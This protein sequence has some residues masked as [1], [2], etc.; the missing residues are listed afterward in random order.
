MSIEESQPSELAAREE[1]LASLQGDIDDFIS[2][3]DTECQTGHGSKTDYFLHL[4]RPSPSSSELTV[5]NIQFRGDLREKGVFRDFLKYVE[6]RTALS[7]IN[8][9]TIQSDWLPEKLAAYG[10]TVE[11]QHAVK[12]LG[13]PERKEFFFRSH[14]LDYEVLRPLSHIWGN[15][16]LSWD[17]KNQAYL[18]EKDSFASVLNQLIREISLTVVP[19]RYHDNEDVLVQYVRTHLNWPLIKKGRVWTGEDYDV[20]LQQGGFH[21]IDEKDFVAAAT[22]RVQAAL[23]RNQHHYDQMEEGHRRMLASVLTSILY[24]RE[25]LVPKT[26]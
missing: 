26:E 19:A 20:I 11:G 8:F 13:S 18:E 10:Y 7:E 12:Y 3:N 5:Y 15:W 14:S 9:S 22:G 6:S 24:H 25:R 17:Q 21:D 23:D 4:K 16:E 1:L 2:G